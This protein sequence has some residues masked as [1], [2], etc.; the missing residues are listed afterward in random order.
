MNKINLI[1]SGV[2][3]FALLSII[4]ILNPFAQVSAG[5]R[6]VVLTWGAAG[7]QVLTEGLH[8]VTPIAQHVQIVDIRVQ[9]EQVDVAAASKDLQTVN[10]TVAINFHPDPSKVNIL[11][12]TI[13]SDYSSRIISPVV[14]EGVKA[15]TARYTAEE[16]I[17][18]REEV[19]DGIKNILTER[20][21][22]SNILIDDFSIMNFSFSK[23]FNDAIEA[24]QTAVQDAL[25]AE[26]KL[27]Q[28]K[29]EAEQRVA[30]AQAEA[31]AIKLQS[32]AANNDKYINLKALEV[33]LEAVHKWNGVLPTQMTPN[34]AVPF[35]NLTK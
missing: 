28:I 27:R 33:Q 34:G 6:G 22:L 35:L 4:M 19:R 9:K 32:D 13:G 30:T 3:A 24:K 31:Q 29:V 1:I 20:L 7:D 10:S 2:I 5:E 21:S 11:W 12:K 23:G 8:M 14:Q 26:N 25:T 18:K 17:T 16:L 15:V